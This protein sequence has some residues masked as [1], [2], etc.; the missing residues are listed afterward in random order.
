MPWDAPDFGD[1]NPTRP[2]SPCHG[3]QHHAQHRILWVFKMYQQCHHRR[4]FPSFS[5]KASACTQHP[6]NYQQTPLPPP[7]SHQLLTLSQRQSRSGSFFHLRFSFFFCAFIYIYIH[8]FCPPLLIPEITNVTFRCRR[9]GARRAEWATK[10]DSPRIVQQCHPKRLIGGRSA[11]RAAFLHYYYYW[12]FLIIVF[13]LRCFLPSLR[14]CTTPPSGA[15]GVIVGD[16]RSRLKWVGG[17]MAASIPKCT[18]GSWGAVDIRVS[19]AVGSQLQASPSV[20][21]GW[22][23]GV[24]SLLGMVAGNPPKRVLVVN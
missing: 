14:K 1:S 22:D 20:F 13:Y 9:R 5:D 2:P 6:E 18:V 24:E 7:S 16:E 17:W 10:I 15:R 19:W 21:L 3:D 4:C 11:L 23:N 8:I 12:F